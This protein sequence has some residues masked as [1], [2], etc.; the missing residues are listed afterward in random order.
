VVAAWVALPVLACQGR[1]GTQTIGLPEGLRWSAAGVAGICYGL[2]AYCWSTMGRNWSMAVVPD[3]STRLVTAGPYRWVRHP[4]YS[5]SIVMMLAT[6]VVLPVGAMILTAALHIVALNLKAA[7]EEL[8]LAG[9]F[10]SEY[11]RYTRTAG[12]FWPRL[13]QISE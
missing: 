2:S 1:L 4:I 5:L 12:R 13:R 10:G 8:H 7:H 6:A 11:A 9:R 3:Q